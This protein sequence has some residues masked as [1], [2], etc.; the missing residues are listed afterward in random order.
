MQIFAKREIGR[1]DGGREKEGKRYRTI[2]RTEQ[3]FEKN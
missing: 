3:N 2:N 1:R